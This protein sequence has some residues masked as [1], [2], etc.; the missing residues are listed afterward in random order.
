MKIEQ[1]DHAHVFEKLNQMLKQRT[2]F[3]MRVVAAV[4]QKEEAE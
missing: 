3:L 2:T 1:R 4:G